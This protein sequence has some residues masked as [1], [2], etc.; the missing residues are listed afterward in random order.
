VLPRRAHSASASLQRHCAAGALQA[1]AGEAAQP[2]SSAP[3]LSLR[4]ALAADAWRLRAW[5]RVCAW[6]TF[7]MPSHAMHAVDPRRGSCEPACTACCACRDALRICGATL[8]I[9]YMVRLAQSLPACAR[10][11]CR[12]S[13]REAGLFDDWFCSGAQALQ[14]TPSLKIGGLECAKIQGQS[15]MHQD[16]LWWG[17]GLLSTS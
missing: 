15:G 8:R 4:E 1:G 7:W 11:C 12:C 10:P 13:T 3:R 14:S 16:M 9:Q 5:V 6:R 2:K 17:L